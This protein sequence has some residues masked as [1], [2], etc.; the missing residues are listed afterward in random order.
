MKLC[1]TISR[2]RGFCEIYGELQKDI[3]ILDSLKLFSGSVPLINLAR[4]SMLILYKDTTDNLFFY[5]FMKDNCTQI[6]EIL[7]LE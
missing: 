1:R 7:E 3:Q 4:F 5:V 6:K 2:F